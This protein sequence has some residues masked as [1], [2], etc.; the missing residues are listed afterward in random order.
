MVVGR[1]EGE[2]RFLLNNLFISR[3]C[4]GRL[5]SSF[6][7][8]AYPGEE[9]AIIIESVP[10]VAFY[11]CLGILRG[12]FSEQVHQLGIIQLFKVGIGY[13]GAAN[14]ENIMQKPFLNKR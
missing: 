8:F 9:G 6:D 12:L 14:S 4:T 2:I 5:L 10:T 11:Q 3:V 13:H 1:I 7:L